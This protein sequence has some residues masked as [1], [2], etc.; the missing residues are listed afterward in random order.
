MKPVRLV[1]LTAALW[2]AFLCSADAQ[3]LCADRQAIV[4]QL[5]AQHG[6]KLAGIGLTANGQ[7]LEL[8]AAPSGNWTIIMTRPDGASCLMSV[9]EGW[10]S[11]Q[12]TRGSLPGREVSP[13]PGSDPEAGA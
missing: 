3:V 5:G 11:V 8:F 12:P 13:S 4:D 7:V 2:A 1:F 10:Q 9:G 6:E